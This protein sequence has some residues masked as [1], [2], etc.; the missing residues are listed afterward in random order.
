MRKLFILF[1]LLALTV[2]AVSAQDDLANVDPTGVT[3]DYW[4]QFNSGEQLETMNALVEDFN[5]NNEYGIT[6][7]ALAQGNYN[8]IRDL[9]NAGIVSGELPNIAAGYA[10][11]AASYA[12]DAAAQDL[13]FY[14][15]SPEWGLGDQLEGDFNAALLPFNEVNGELL[16]WPHQ[17]S[18]QVFVYNQT[19][20]EELGFDGPARDIETFVEQ[21]CASAQSTTADGTQRLGYPITTDS[22]QFESWVAAFGGNIYNA[23]TGEYQFTSE[24]ALNAL[25]LYADLYT[26]GCGYIPAERFAEQND[27]ALGLTPFMS[28]STAGFTF[29]V[30]AFDASGYEAEWS[31]TTFPH[32]EGNE[33]LQVF[34]PSIILIGGTPEEQLASWIFLR[35]LVSPEAA[36]QW[37]AGTGYFNPVPSTAEVVTADS[38]DD[39]KV[40]ELFTTANNLLNNPDIELYGGPSIS[41]QGTVRGFVS[42]AIA[43]V[44]SNEMPVQEAAELLQ[45]QAEQ[46]LADSM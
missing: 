2:G 11:D 41:A 21:A 26:S 19:L 40:G 37:S 38:F 42:E 39:P 18:A 46:A 31:V 22:S 25:Q 5:A 36:A 30:A 44:T 14:L 15:N 13:Y 32:T 20:L 33:I 17:S 29:I 16:A 27:F 9:I 28:T 45:Q 43:N 34:V 3:I 35:Y 6:V 12:L 7:N 24:P 4:H 23:E 8:D 1:C 10:N